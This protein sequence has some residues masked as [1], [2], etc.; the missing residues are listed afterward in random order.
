MGKRYYSR[1]FTQEPVKLSIQPLH[2]LTRRCSHCGGQF[3]ETHRAFREY[4]KTWLEAEF[5]EPAH[6]IVNRLL[7]E[8][9][10]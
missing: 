7:A 4:L 5:K 8:V 9:R 3:V 2:S 6:A 10:S 1:H